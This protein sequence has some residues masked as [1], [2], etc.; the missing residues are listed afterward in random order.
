MIRPWITIQRDQ[1][2]PPP[3][4]T[5]LVRFNEYRK[6]FSQRWRLQT[7][8]RC[9][10]HVPDPCQRRREF[11]ETNIKY[12]R[13]MVQ[14]AHQKKNASTVPSVITRYKKK[15]QKLITCACSTHCIRHINS[16][17]HDLWRNILGEA[18]MKTG[19]RVERSMGQW[20]E[21]RSLKGRFQRS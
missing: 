7:H 21:S 10:H 14:H 13:L 9:H 16:Q 15:R 11:E 12:W 3:Y 6:H 1:T 4:P 2:P 18:E 19:K 20:R 8:T 5:S 17:M